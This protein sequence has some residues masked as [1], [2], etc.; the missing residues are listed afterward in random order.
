M[1]TSVSTTR[2]D[3]SP[4][5]ARR[6]RK[7]WHE[8]E[9]SAVQVLL[10]VAIIAPFVVGG[11][12][13]YFRIVV[14]AR[15]SL[16]I[17]PPPSPPIPVPFVNPGIIVVSPSETDTPVAPSQIPESQ[18]RP[19]KHRAPEETPV[20]TTPPVPRG[21]RQV[22]PAQIPTTPPPAPSTTP[23]APPPSGSTAR[24][25][26]PRPTVSSSTPIYDSLRNETLARDPN[27]ETV[28]PE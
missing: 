10:W 18:R 20:T 9:R 26:P 7:I 12:Y 3:L 15:E 25:E 4:L 19:G 17:S 1:S 22:A 16:Q 11:E 21:S 2:P 24:S 28:I 23:S 13:I 14:P 5:P 8:I 27:L 6:K